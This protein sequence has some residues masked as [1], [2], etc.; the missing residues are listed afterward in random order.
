M[1]EYAQRRTKIN[2]QVTSDIPRRGSAW[3]FERVEGV[4]NAELNQ[5]PTQSLSARV[6]WYMLG[7]EIAKI[8]HSGG[9]KQRLTAT[10]YSLM[11]PKQIRKNYRCLSPTW[12]FR[13]HPVH[14][15]RGYFSCLSHRI[16][17]FYPLEIITL[18]P[19]IWWRRLCGSQISVR[20]F[21]LTFPSSPR[22]VYECTR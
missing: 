16:P 20:D 8:R 7:A 15:S 11:K 9:K 22:L 10:V 5:K 3:D 13:R 21:P 19:S 18:A 14:R 6:V 2:F 1:V 4:E 17:P 12:I